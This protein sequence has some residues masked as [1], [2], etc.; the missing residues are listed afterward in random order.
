MSTPP[1]TWHIPAP[2]ELELDLELVDPVAVFDALVDVVQLVARLGIVLHGDDTLIIHTGPHQLGTLPNMGGRGL[3][4]AAR[5]FH[6]HP[7]ATL[8]H[9]A[10]KA[11]VD[12]LKAALERVP[13]Q[14]A[15]ADRDR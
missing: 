10:A 15:Y 4:Y 1:V 14:L 9:A 7:D 5:V 11:A 6:G 2:A 8:D 12:E 3:P 13:Y